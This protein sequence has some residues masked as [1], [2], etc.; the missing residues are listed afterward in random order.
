MKSKHSYGSKCKLNQTMLSVE[1][2]D[3]ISILLF[4]KDIQ[5]LNHTQIHVEFNLAL[6]FDVTIVNI[7]KKNAHLS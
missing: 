6:V 7:F 3:R 2:F 5:S 4:P 1:S